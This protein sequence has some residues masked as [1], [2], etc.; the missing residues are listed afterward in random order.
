MKRKRP[1]KPPVKS[2][3]FADGDRITWRGRPGIIKKVRHASS[4]LPD[5]PP[6]AY[7]IILDDRV[8]SSGYEGTLLSARDPHLRPVV[9]HDPHAA[10][11]SADPERNDP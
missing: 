9:D 4:V 7:S 10:V 8:G 2:N 3:A 11:R 1:P 6:L 5:S